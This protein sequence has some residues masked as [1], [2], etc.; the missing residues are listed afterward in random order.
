MRG[1]WLDGLAISA[2]LLCLIH[3]LAL[4]IMVL[5][6]PLIGVALGDSEWF[7]PLI[8]VFA[9]PTSSYALFRGF[10]EHGQPKS[11]I[12]GF[13]GLLCL[14]FGIWVEHFALFGTG[15]TVAG[16][17]FLAIGHFQ[18]LRFRHDPRLR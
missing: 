18:N 3:C 7:H 14:F 16:S 13:S 12:F 10:R 17:L 4:P 15:L 5:A 1:K 2:S 9:I 11:L 6:L 8:L